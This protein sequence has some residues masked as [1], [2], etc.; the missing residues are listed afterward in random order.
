MPSNSNTYKKEEKTDCTQSSVPHNSSEPTTI[1]DA[2]LYMATTSHDTNPSFLFLQKSVACT[3]HH[4]DVSGRRAYTAAQLISVAKVQLYFRLC[5]N[6]Y[7][8]KSH[9]LHFFTF[10]ILIRPDRVADFHGGHEVLHI[11]VVE[12]RAGSY[13]ETIETHT[14]LFLCLDDFLRF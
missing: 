1:G 13:V 7:T 14:L 3:Y 4:K 10:S 9:T 5:N 12:R 2:H 6:Y 8:Y 11:Q